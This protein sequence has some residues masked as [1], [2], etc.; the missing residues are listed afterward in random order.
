MIAKWKV[1]NFKSIKEETELDFAPLTI[2]AGAN[3]SGKSTFIQS[4]LLVAQTLANKVGS[5]SVVLNGALA[6]L[7]QFDDLKSYG[8]A[9]DFI[10][11][12]C[13]CETLEKGPIS[14]ISL[15]ILYQGR[16]MLGNRVGRLK[17][18]D[19]EITFDSGVPGVENELYQIQPRLFAS[20]VNCTFRDQDNI[21]Q[22]GSISVRYKSNDNSTD[23]EL[24]ISERDYPESVVNGLNYEVFLDTAGESELKEEYCSADLLGVTLKHFLPDRILVG[25]DK[26]KENSNIIVQWL[27]NNAFSNRRL[28]YRVSTA[29]LVL[30]EKMI[31]VLKRI[32]SGKEFD[33][34]FEKGQHQYSIFLSGRY[35]LPI[36]QFIENIKLLSKEDRFHAQ[37]LLRSD[38]MLHREMEQAFELLDFDGKQFELVQWRPERKIAES[39]SYLNSFFSFSLRYLGPLREAPRPIYPLSPLADPNDIGLHGEHTAAVLEL[40]KERKITYIPSENFKPAFADR[41]T[42]VRTLESAVNDWLQYLGVAQKVT[43]KDKGK[44]GHELSVD[45][46]EAGTSHDLTHVGVG[47]SQVLPILVMCLLAKE[48]STLVFEQPE[49]H[50]HPRVQTL[51]GDFFLSMGF[52]NKQ[53]IVETHSEY[54]IDRLRFRMASAP[55]D[56]PLSELAK[57]YFVEKKKGISEFRQVKI[58]DY[59]AITDWPDGFFDQSQS[60]AEAILRAAAKKRDL[61]RRENHGQ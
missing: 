1:G 6:S 16:S 26:K 46:G 15:P 33:S 61:F 24:E 12:K 43:T 50:L 11:I 45:L 54:L 20:S 9:T 35:I 39:M 23:L 36:D 40:H 7:G 32:L 22:K 57:V 56:A 30:N 19:C 44:L 13:T 37:E 18:V 25:I 42:S 59:G 58:N 53:C 14:G 5:R 8:S 21:D 2:F 38:E 41:T 3:S 4:I 52:C 49:L 28:D 47:V 60:E 51:L 10:T 34:L 29:E 31:D 48:D 17:Q 27:T 55:I